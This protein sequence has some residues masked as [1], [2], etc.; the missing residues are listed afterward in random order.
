VNRQKLLSAV[1][2]FL[3]IVLVIAGVGWIGWRLIAPQFENLR[4][5]DNR[6]IIPFHDHFDLDPA[7]P[8]IILEGQRLTAFTPLIHND[9][10]FLPV[11]FIRE[12]IDPFMFWDAGAQTLLV[13]TRE[14][15]LAF[16]LGDVRNFEGRIFVPA[17]K[18]MGLYPFSVVFHPEY[19]MVVVTDDRIPQ[20]VANVSGITP[21]RYR[22]DT[23]AP[24]TTE[25]QDFAMVTLFGGEGLWTR[26]RTGAGLLGYVQTASLGAALYTPPVPSR[27]WLFS[28]GYVDNVQPREPNW[29][30]GKINMVWELVYFQVTNETNMQT[31]LPESLTVISPTWFRFNAETMALD[32]VACVDYIYWAWEQGVQVWPNVGDASAGPAG[33]KAILSNAAARRRIVEQLV[34]YVYT[35]ELEGLSI[36][37]EHIFEFHYGAYFVQFMRELNIALGDK[38][39]LLAAM[40]VCPFTNPHYRHDLIAK[41]IDFIALMTFDEHHGHSD[42][43]P[44]ASLPWV[45]RQVAEMLRRV[46]ANQ[47]LMG[48]PFYNRV[49]RTSVAEGTRRTSLVW[50]MDRA[51]REFYNRGVSFEWDAAIGSY[52]AEFAE[53]VEGETLRHQLWKECAR[54]I[55]KKMQ[56]YAVYNL[57]GV[58][59]WMNGFTNQEVWDVLGTYF[60]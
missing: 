52:Y 50:D 19:N 6:E 11:D 13:T 25:L 10:A 21:V 5:R 14:E 20:R 56:L 7:I 48:L 24:I 8:H 38:V 28:S 31:P 58:A 41:T 23:T 3:V 57:A 46:P 47:L 51:A 35:L 12:F 32:S 53:V 42:P 54:S 39:I 26:V 17:D 4:D 22:P 18:V 30:G 45:E 59:G 16:R 2:S 27:S 60:P 40:K 1:V 29:D 9:T 43:G 49:W 36:N 55:G 15:M 44:T 37:I 33:I 34:D